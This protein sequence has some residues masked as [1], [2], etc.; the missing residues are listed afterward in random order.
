MSLRAQI[1]A[2]KDES[3]KKDEEQI[4]FSPS[5]TA[6]RGR[7]KEIKPILG[8]RFDNLYTDAVK[9]KSAEAIAK[10][11]AE[12]KNDVD[13]TFKPTI[14]SKARSISR[15]RSSSTDRLHN[16]SGAGRLLVKELPIDPHLFKPLIS[17][18]ASSLTRSSPVETNTRLYESRV[19][20]QE[21]KKR[22]KEEADKKNSD[23]C[24]FSPK[25]YRSRSASRENIPNKNLTS[26]V[27]R[28]LK[29]GENTKQKI[30][31]EKL[32]RRNNELKDMTFQPQ[33]IKHSMNNKGEKWI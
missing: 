30:E 16:A 28:L 4:T 33:V 6:R 10:A 19:K 24:T 7:D 23:L 31:E 8:S 22:E 11:A 32:T 21:S 20:N 18:R 26:V 5:L 15:D 12:E 1:A 25:L 17:K 27:D 2:R 3:K 29:S 14:S 13:N 9:R